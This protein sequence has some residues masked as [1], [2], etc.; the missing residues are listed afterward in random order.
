MNQIFTVAKHPDYFTKL[1][2]FKNKICLLLEFN[3]LII[4]ISNALSITSR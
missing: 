4:C 3:F 1:F 2:S